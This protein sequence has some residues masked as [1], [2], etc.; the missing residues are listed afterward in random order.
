MSRSVFPYRRG[1]RTIALILG[2]LLLLPGLNGTAQ[3][4]SSPQVDLTKAASN[5]TPQPG[6]PFTYT[7]NYRCASTTAN[8]LNVVISDVLPPELASSASDVQLTGIDTNVATAGYDPATRTVTWNMVSP[9][10]AGTTGQLAIQVRFAPGSTLPG[11]PALNT[12]AASGSNTTATT[13][14]PITVTAGAAELKLEPRKTVLDSPA[15]TSP[16]GQPHDVNYRVQVCSADA[17]GGLDLLNAT[18]VDTLPAGAT[19]VSAT[20]GGT[21]DATANTITWTE[22]RIA[23]TGGCVWSNTVTV[24]YPDPPFADAQ[25]VTNNLDLTGT[26]LGATAAVT[27]GTEVSHP[28]SAPRAEANASK[29]TQAWVDHGQPYTY[30]LSASNTGGTDLDMT[31]TD[32]IGAQVWVQSVSITSASAT[33]PVIGRYQ[34]GGTSIW[35]PFPA[36]PYTST[37][38]LT[39]ADLGLAGAQEI[40][41]VELRQTLP[42]PQPDTASL[43]GSITAEVRATDRSGAPVPFGSTVTNCITTSYLDEAG[44]PDGGSACNDVEVVDDFAVP[45]VSKSPSPSSARPGQ[46]VTYSITLANATWASAPLQ[47]FT[48]ADVL[49]PRVQYV[50]GSMTTG[51]VTSSGGVTMTPTT[52]AAGANLS[53]QFAEPLAIGDS[54][55][56][57]YQV[58]V[59]RTTAPGQV[60]NAVSVAGWDTRV[61]NNTFPCGEAGNQSC[62]TTVNLDVVTVAGLESSKWVKGSNDGD[63]ESTVC[64][65]PSAECSFDADG[66]WRR[67]PAVSLTVPG[68]DFD[69]KLRLR[70]PGNVELGS[71]SIVDILPF[72]SDTGVIDLSGRSSQWRPTLTGPVAG[73]TQIVNA[74]LDGVFGTA[75]DGAPTA[76]TAG[77]FEARYSTQANPCRP[78]LVAAPG[79]VAATWMTWAE[80]QSSATPLASLRSLKFDFPGLTLGPLD[81]IDFTFPMRAPANAPADLVAWN[82]YGFTTTRVDNGSTLLPAEPI[83]VGIKL[84]REEGIGL[85]DYVWFDFD[86][87]GIQDTQEMG[88]PPTLGPARPTGI[89]GLTV[90]VYE[91]GPDGEPGGG[92]DILVDEATTA[93]DWRGIPGY[94]F[95]PGLSA[96]REYFVAFDNTAVGTNHA[97][98]SPGTRPVNLEPTTADAA[99]PS[100][101]AT[102]DGAYD[103]DGTSALEGDYAGWAITPIFLLADTATPTKINNDS[104]NDPTWDMGFVDP[105]NHKVSLG[106]YTWL[107]SN[108]NGTQDVSE[109]DLDGVTAT[110]RWAGPNGTAGDGDDQ[111]MGSTVTGDNPATPAVE[112]GWYTFDWL[113]GSTY[114]VTFGAPV[115]YT[116]TLANVAAA[117]EA[118][119]SDA[120]R[121]TGVAPAVTLPRD[122]FGYHDPKID[123]GF[124]QAAGIGN[125]VWEDLNANGVQDSGEPGIDGVRVHLFDA[126]NVEIGAMDTAGGGIYHFGN[127]APGTYHVGFDLPTGYTRSPADASGV[128]DA[129]DSD[130]STATGLTV[131]TELANGEDDLTWDAG[132]Y[133][134]VRVGNFVWIDQDGDGQQDSG[135]PGV[136]GVTVRL[137]N[138]LGELVD[139]MVTGDTGL[140][141][142]EGLTP[143]SYRVEFDGTTLPAGYRVTKANKGADGTDSDG[144]TPPATAS[145]PSG[146]EDLTLD[147]GIYL[148]V[149]VGDRVWHDRNGDGQQADPLVE[150]GVGG[151]TVRVYDILDNLVGTDT[152]ET[153]GSW[154]VEGLAPGQYRAAFDWTTVPA[155]MRPT[156]SN[157][158]ADTSDSDADPT[159]GRTALTP[160]LNSGSRDLTLDAGINNDV[161][162]GD[163]VW[164]DLNANGRQDAGEPGIAG[165]RV[166]IHDDATGEPVPGAP[167]LTTDENG[168]YRFTGLRPGNYY[169]VFD[170]STLPAGAF[171][172]RTDAAGVADD[173]DS[174]GPESAPTGPIPS[175]GQ[176]LTLDL[177]IFRPASIGNIIWT[178][179]DADGVQDVGETG[180]AGATV[181]LLNA[182]GSPAT[183]VHNEPI[184]PIVTTDTGAYLFANLRPGD[185]KVKVVPPSGARLT[186]RDAA[187]ATDL[188]DS[189]VDTASGETIVTSL[190]SGENDLTWD[191]GIFV[192]ASV[193]DLVWHDLDTDGIHDDGEPGVAG[194]T[195]E[196]LGADGTVVATTTTASDGTYRFENLR[197]GDYQVRV[198]PPTGFIVSDPDQGG[199]DALDS[200]V[201]I[202]TGTTSTITL[203]SG[204]NDP[205]WDA[206]IFEAASLGDLVWE[207]RDRDGVKDADEP[208]VAGVA[209]TLVDPAGNVVGTTT[210]DA[211]GGYRFEGLRPGDYKVR[212][213]VPATWVVTGHNAGGD[214]T[215]DS[216]I[217]PVTFETAVTTVGRNT[218]VPSVDAGIYQPYN[219]VITKAATT[220]TVMTDG[221]ASWRITVRNDGPGRAYG[222]LLIT[223]N[224]PA[225]LGYVSA[226]GT[227]MS[228]SGSGSTVTCTL[229]GNLDSGSSAQLD[230]VTSVSAEAGTTVVNQASV[231]GPGTETATTDNAAVASI[232][233]TARPST[234]G[235]DTQPDFAG[236]IAT[237]GARVGV[238]LGAGLGLL[239]LGLALTRMTRRQNG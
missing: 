238:L 72:V 89:N 6:E 101:D 194:V 8:C 88:L 156:A 129:G 1:G 177:G 30:G 170:G 159:T 27:E 226:S 163:L 35:L 208:G 80:V 143:G 176:N 109:P 124:F 204:E 42:Y 123:A 122:V 127:L 182:D 190:I 166:T 234:G 79:C 115:G 231:A 62:T 91:P 201:S 117:G 214:D 125:L 22:P 10:G 66:T 175:G 221:N 4:Q 188:S 184:A 138:G 134:P 239:L 25:S 90:R 147:L 120:D 205:T 179:V 228:C 73:P 126:N 154:L 187:S 82:S 160:F 86:N 106:D 13:S 23:D 11:T 68:G 235:S 169:V 227:G 17:V 197:P 167:V 34:V 61:T 3:A 7:I 45:S 153:D 32:T 168:L 41:A 165:V 136:A 107:D 75:D 15:Y 118:A 198:T 16:A 128:P 98:G 60:P 85:G 217:D 185:Y 69:Y 222:P 207:D 155:G 2:M 51:A 216:D 87:D 237:T 193:G 63:D 146:S 162:I 39:K 164:E 174:D 161:L 12:V 171:V 192:P 189:D 131:P 43:T 21:Y 219:L 31:I 224:L 48:I 223:D 49:D 236:R 18:I 158:G 199:N 181:T 70:N 50:A 47:G 38:T 93:D 172:T 46:R 196:L 78:D 14:A 225:G 28:L 135:E 20:G 215:T 209:V 173:V 97:D 151:V 133:R 95:V 71:L 132:I 19:F 103:S 139:D 148:P 56:V 110:L 53:W 29:S 92:D 59:L 37:V 44:E 121:T 178:D 64:P 96:E 212:V 74:G 152:T 58:D 24:R 145:L 65:A 186:T 55:T 5:A 200:D 40:G 220:A 119:D 203:V 54:V 116:P 108:A 94:W 112:H 113:V 229:A 76:L 130:A 150:P 233:V 104:P 83:K 180:V 213:T 202:A 211:N 141:L 142:F 140:Y 57:T 84:A 105:D 114:Y 33:N 195:V 210:T 67:F 77:Q 111:V 102:A 206:G 191:A 99:N 157:Q 218:H 36:N 144:L 26:A 149:A 230:V 81:G 52:A 183:D 232:R 9:L 137:Y 100:G